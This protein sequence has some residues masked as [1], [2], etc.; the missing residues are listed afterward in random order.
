[1]PASRSRRWKDRTIRKLAWFHRWL[2][3]ATCLVFAL[4]FA[5]GAVLLFKPFPSL[6][7]DAQ[8]ALQQIVNVRDVSIS[9]GR[10]IAVAGGEAVA[11]RL[12]E[13][14]GTPAYVVDTGKNLVAVDART[15]IS[16]PLLGADQA[17]AIG[18]SIFG[19]SMLTG[20]PITYDQWVVHNHFDPL[21][22]FFRLDANDSKGTQFYVSAITGELVQRTTW[23]DRAWNF[24]GAVLH[25]VYFTPLRSSFT[26]WDRTVWI[27]SFVAMLVA[28]AGTVLGVIRTMQAQRQRKPS[29]SFYRRKWMRWHHILG[30]FASLFVLTWILSGWLSMDHGRLFSRGQATPDQ[31]AAY[32]G[33]PLNTA[34]TAFDLMKLQALPPSPEI[35]FDVIDGDLVI[36]ASGQ[37]GLT[38]LY[39]SGG[40]V[41]S[42]DELIAL[43]KRGVGAAWP[44]AKVVGASP[45]V[46]TDV[47]TLAEGWPG[48]TVQ[49]SLDGADAPSVYIDGSNGRLLTV[50]SNSRASYAW[51][52]Y[53]LHTFNFPGLTT[54]P[55][56]R[57]VIVMIP[58]IF[59][60]LFSIT[61]II[62]GVQR[63]R[64]TF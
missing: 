56:L 61:G 20:A 24:V 37:N 23:G 21:R 58:L 34:L 41:M 17:H 4:W 59:G 15:G 57:E 36:V 48:S 10:A 46:P 39:D 25:W 19:R 30:L 6:S 8:M 16:L 62:L 1:M 27:L 3:I 53:A 38:A 40:R 60:F 52:Y 2:G 5:S 31:L 54:R 26:A 7:R 32:H 51:I 42:S 44:K 35:A 45:V 28:I 47:Y 64:K 13:R 18:T 43:A 29:L 49:I 9:P 33:R 14:G 11:L 50:M 22:P 63:V 12:I 55:V